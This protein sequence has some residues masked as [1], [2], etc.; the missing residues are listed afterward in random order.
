MSPLARADGHADTDL[1]G[2]LGDAHEHDVHDADP[3]HEQAD[4]GD[5]EE[6][7]LEHGGDAG[8]RLAHLFLGVDLEVGVGPLGDAVTLAQDAGDLRGGAIDHVLRGGAE[9]QLVEPA[10]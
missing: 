6:E 3:A 5:A 9:D 1:A 7:E 2:A 10:R 8:L 4:G